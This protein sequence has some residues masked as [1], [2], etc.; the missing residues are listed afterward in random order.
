[1]ACLNS[2][3]KKLGLNKT[4]VAERTAIK[5]MP[6][7]PDINK[8]RKINSLAICSIARED[9]LFRPPALKTCSCNENN[10][11]WAEVRISHSLGCPSFKVSVA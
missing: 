1:M 9:C 11:T 5:P 7:P 6:R 10:R 2:A 3:P 8:A 4:F